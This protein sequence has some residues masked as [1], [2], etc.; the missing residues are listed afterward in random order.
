ME[1]LKTWGIP[2]AGLIIWLGLVFSLIPIAMKYLRAKAQKSKMVLD[3]LLVNALAFPLI[4]F[5]VSIG[6]KVFFDAVP[7]TARRSISSQHPREP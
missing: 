4:I 6:L 1:L 2:S 5:L 3:D 7:G